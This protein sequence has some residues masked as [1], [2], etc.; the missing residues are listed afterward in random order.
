MTGSG[1]Y[2]GY[3]ILCYLL[4]VTVN[5]SYELILLYVWQLAYALY[6]NEYVGVQKVLTASQDKNTVNNFYSIAT[7]I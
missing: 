7:R 5:Y 6:L 4:T 2:D 3:I 1:V